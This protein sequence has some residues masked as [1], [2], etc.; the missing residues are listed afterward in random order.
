MKYMPFIQAPRRLFRCVFYVVSVMHHHSSS[1]MTGTISCI[2][3]DLWTSDSV[4]FSHVFIKFS[5]GVLLQQIHLLCFSWVL[6]PHAQCLL[7]K[8]MSD[9]STPSSVYRHLPT[10]AVD[11]FSKWNQQLS[12]T[13]GTVSFASAVNREAFVVNQV[14]R[15]LWP[16]EVSVHL[17][18][19]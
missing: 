12:K 3:T 13:Q 8:T 4:P 1:C 19:S 7:V 2:S 11:V 5:M 15:G 14:E 10:D 16:P 18:L 17:S 9:I 6:L